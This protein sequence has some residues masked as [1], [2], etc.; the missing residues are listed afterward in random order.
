MYEHLSS[1]AA[2]L[3]PKLAVELIVFSLNSGALAL[4]ERKELAVFD[5]PLRAHLAT[6]ATCQ[7]RDVTEVRDTAQLAGHGHHPPLPGILLPL[8]HVEA[9]HHRL[10]VIFPVKESVYKGCFVISEGLE[11]YVDGEH[12]CVT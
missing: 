12:N 7:R 11:L 8:R 3:C 6:L 5:V 9:H 2:V 10:L 4:P 1:T